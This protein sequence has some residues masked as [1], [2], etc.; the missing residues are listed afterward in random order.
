VRNPQP[1]HAGQAPDPATGAIITPIFQTSTYVQDELGK[2]KGFE[3]AR[4]QNPTRSALEANLAA[5]EGGKAAFAFA[6]GMSA[7]ANLTPLSLG[8]SRKAALRDSRSSLA[9]TGSALMTRAR[10]RARVSSGRSG[11]RSLST[12]VKRVEAVIERQQRMSPEGDDQR[13]FLLAENR[14]AAFLRSLRRI[15]DALALAP[16]RHRLRVD[17]VS[18]AQLRDRSLRSLYPSS[19]GLRGRGAPVEYLAHGA[20]L[21]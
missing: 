19:D 14:R 10:C 6:S 4:T 17:P 3:Y 7:A 18:P 16:L 12:S 1:I 11:L 20:S 13:L 8:G 2:H 9:I 15:V 5:I 21:A